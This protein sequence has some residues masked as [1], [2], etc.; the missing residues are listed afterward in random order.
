MEDKITLEGQR[1]IVTLVKL[2]KNTVFEC[3]CPESSRENCPNKKLLMIIPDRNS[4]ICCLAKVAIKNISNNPLSIHAGDELMQYSLIDTDRQIYVNQTV[5]KYIHW[6]LNSSVFC[7]N[8]PSPA[9]CD[10]L[11][12]KYPDPGIFRR[13]GFFIPENRTGQ[14]Y[15]VF[16]EMPVK[17]DI[18]EL[19]VTIDRE[20]FN[21][22]IKTNIL[23]KYRQTTTEIESLDIQ[24]INDSC[25]SPFHQILLAH[26][27]TLRRA[28]NDM[29]KLES[30]LSSA[31]VD[32]NPH[33]I[34]AA[35]FAFKGPL[36][37]GAI[38]CDEVGL[39]KTIEAGL[40]IC[41]LW[42]EGKRKIIVVVPA[43]IRKQWQNELLEKFNVPCIIVDGVEYKAAQ[44]QGTINP[45][46]RG[47][48]V[49]VSI[50]FASMKASEIAAVGRWDLV[51]I[52]ESH[53]LRNV[54]KKTGSKQAKRLKDIFAGMPK[55]LLTATPLQNSLL[56]LYGLISFIDERIVGSEYSFRSR[57]IAD[58]LGH[59]PN[60][61]ELLKERISS[62]A[63]RTIRRQV[64]E[65]IPYTNRIS[66]TE[67]FTQTDEEIELYNLVSEYLQRQEVAAIPYKQRHL[68]ILI[69][70]KIL[71]SS[72]FAIAQTLQS[73]VDNIQRQIEG[74]KPESIEELVKDVD[75]YEEE[76]EEIN[77]DEDNTE[78]ENGKEEIA[79]KKFTIEQLKTE[80]DE[81]ISM[82]KFA[83]SINKNAKGDALLIALDKT[84]KHAN[85]MGWNEKAV[86]FTE[87]RR[88]QEYLLRLLSN[89]GYQD[90]ITVFNGTNNGSIATR[91]YNIWKKERTRYEGEGILSRDAVIREALIHEFK[92]H[93]KILIATEA[94]AE[95]INLQFCNIVIN[96]DLP[97]NPQRVEQRI[98]RC[99]R[100]GQK[101]DVVVLN[102]LNRSNAADRRV[103]ELL[104]MKFRLFSG[105]F[106]A[107]DEILGAVSS[108]VDFEKRIL[109]IYQSCRTEEEIN[110]AFDRLQNELS[111]QIN[112]HMI[113][114][115]AKLLEHFDDEVRARFK[116][117][118]KRVHEDLSAIDMTLVKIISNA[119]NIKECEMKEG[120]CR[121]KIDSLPDHIT[122]ST[123]DRLMPGSYY[124]GKYNENIEGE[125]LHIG[126]PLVKAIISH[127][128][129]NPKD[130]IYK[131][132]LDYTRKHKISQLVPYLGKVGFWAVYKITYEGLDTEDH[133][134]HIVLL[135]TDDGWTALEQELANK[136]INITAVEMD[137]I[138]SE[139][140][141]MPLP[142]DSILEAEFLKIQNNLFKKI[143]VRNEEY[144]DAELDRLEVYTEEM[145]MKFYDDLK[146]KEEEI[147]EA[148]KK[149]QRAMTFEDRQK[150][151][152]DIHKLEKEYSHL[153]DKIAQEKKLLFEEKDKEMKKLEK[154]LKLKVQKECIAKAWW[155]ME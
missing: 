44:K 155:I 138:D 21:F 14:C 116:V 69:Y 114:T 81:L 123:K 50:P 33:Q 34:D 98:G 68:M 125:R 51:V 91:A 13:P 143:S 124:I 80:Q 85:E 11:H 6:K 137:A 86:I 140:G 55:L 25:T 84:I 8:C 40:I 128:K 56:E 126:H 148:K 110:T 27:L 18:S 62:I 2:Q 145:L 59:E 89:K 111:E 153:A 129:D 46:D 39:G 142:N 87:S 113:E 36:S 42:A 38:L 61:I 79:R 22:R 17:A 154:K 35:L 54:Y 10:V 130:S 63:T 5:C 9:M 118:H 28:S 32:L 45:F 105:V 82:K 112:Q 133:L 146:K 43:S 16:K 96:Y 109:E 100:Y 74:L 66:M 78:E 48:V 15:F 24:Q 52:D 58:S 150:S 71:A 60:N 135:K 108:G 101:N 103:F 131:I 119:L 70:R 75:G 7:S 134:I 151:R 136:F 88:T 20:Q 95:G 1:A 41:Q 94:G 83:E 139:M 99:H 132:K 19:L 30:P 26:E 64:H 65:Y 53:R 47:E 115:R 127:I 93:T 97:W 23:Q 147:A 141:S 76:K 73:L 106:G 37:K 107:S 152:K 102:F 144:Y 31:M 72:S 92:H 104:D 120:I 122:K 121:L 57:F 90:R 77:K 4:L 29:R 117:I 49:I 12:A 67:D 149:K 3:C